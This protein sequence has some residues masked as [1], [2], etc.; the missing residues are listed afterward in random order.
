MSEELAHQKSLVPQ[1]STWRWIMIGIL[2]AVGL[3]VRLYQITDPPI[4]M[5][6]YRSALLARSY[7]YT[8]LA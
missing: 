6:P 8:G 4:N 3:V 7:Y 2:V 5:R 1:G